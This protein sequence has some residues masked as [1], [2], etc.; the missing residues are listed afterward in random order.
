MD[1]HFTLVVSSRRE[2]TLQQVQIALSHPKFSIESPSKAHS[3]LV[4]FSRSVSHFHTKD[5][6]GY[7]FM[8]DKVVEIDHFNPQVAARLVQAFN[9]CSRLEVNRKAIITKELRRINAQGGL[10]KDVGEIIGRILNER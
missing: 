6:G 10:F 1:K 3:L 9:I 5:G 4:N 2:S 8:T 7:R